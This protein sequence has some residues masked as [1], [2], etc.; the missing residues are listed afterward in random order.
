MVQRKCLNEETLTGYLEGLL[1][2]PV[3]AAVEQHVVGCDSC[4]SQ[5]A[6]YMRILDEDVRE[7]EESVVQAALE[8]WSNR[9]VPASTSG[10]VF[11]SMKGLAIAAS[12]LLMATLTLFVSVNWNPGPSPGEVLERL[13]T[14]ERPFEARLALQQYIPRTRAPNM[15]A[16]ASRRLDL[17]LLGGA[18][19]GNYSL[20]M[21]YLLEKNFE[22]AI[23]HL[24]VAVDEAD[25]ASKPAVHNDLGVAHLERDFDSLAQQVMDM[26]IARESFEASLALDSRFAPA[27]FNLAILF[28]RQDLAAEAESRAKAYIDL[29]GDSQWADE[30]RRL[31]D[32]D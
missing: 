5:L 24:E 31:L 20:G 11:S 10:R 4:R 16:G 7:E 2:A 22:M 15:D 21:F 25:A 23:D 12:V 13:L 29:D 6:F 17:N 18:G 27:L 28:S 19:A 30:L 8:R 1:D 32:V 14:E 26:N 3:R 9:S